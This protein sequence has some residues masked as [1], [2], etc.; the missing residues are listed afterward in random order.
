MRW[1]P[2]ITRKGPQGS[3][4]MDGGVIELLRQG[5]ITACRLP[6]GRIAFTLTPDTSQ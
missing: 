5:H 1:Y 6:D 2:A 3:L 4:A